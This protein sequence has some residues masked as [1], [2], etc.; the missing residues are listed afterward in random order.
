MFGIVEINGKQYVER[1]VIIPD[2]VTITSNNQVLTGRSIVLPGTAMFWLKG[3]TRGVI[4]ANVPSTTKPFLFK[5]GN[6]DGSTWYTANGVGGTTDRVLDSLI[7]GDA[8][9]IYPVVP[10]I[11][12]SETGSINYEI[13][14][15]SAS[16]PYTIYL[17]YH[18][19]WLFPFNG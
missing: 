19:S 14:D 10:H 1:T 15:L 11:I 5:F 7:F 13:E 18:G 6:S 12:F 16:V 9:F 3:L 17:A 2:V 8:K 4:A